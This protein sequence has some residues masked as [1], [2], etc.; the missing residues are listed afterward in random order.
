MSFPTTPRII[1]IIIIIRSSSAPVVGSNPVKPWYQV[2]EVRPK[3]ELNQHPEDTANQCYTTLDIPREGPTTTEMWT[4]TVESGRS[5]HEEVVAVGWA[6][7][8]EEAGRV[9][10]KGV[11]AHTAPLEARTAYTYSSDY[12]PISCTYTA[13][14]RRHWWDI[15]EV[16]LEPLKTYGIAAGQSWREEDM[17]ARVEEA[18]HMVRRGK[19]LLTQEE[20]EAQER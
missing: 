1:I 18:L 20:K 13:D 2:C 12:Q 16:A 19:G 8:V 9:L 4:V 3:G 6:R 15:V 5:A 7:D 10:E 14:A 17:A 11:A